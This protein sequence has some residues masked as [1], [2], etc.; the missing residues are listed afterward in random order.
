MFERPI[1][2]PCAIADQTKEGVKAALRWALQRVGAGQVLTLWVMQKGI[3]N[4][5]KFLPALL[6]DAEVKSCGVV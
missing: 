6:K 5:I 2:Y 1:D 4:K 3:L